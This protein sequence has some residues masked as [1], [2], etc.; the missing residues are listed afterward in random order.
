MRNLI[1]ISAVLSPFFLLGQ[2]GFSSKDTLQ[3]ASDS[4]YSRDIIRV[5]KELVFATSKNGVIALNE[6]KEETRQLI[7]GSP[8]GE[9]RSVISDGKTVYGMVSGDHGEVWRT[10]GKDHLL[11][12]KQAGMFFDDM[13]RTDHSFVVLG[14]PVNNEFVLYR[15][16]LTINKVASIE[17]PQSIGDEACYAAS[18]TTVLTSGTTIIFIS[19]GSSAVRY[20]RSDDNG[21]TWTST[22]L[23][24]QVGEGC[25]PF[26]I[27]FINEKDGMIV[28]GCYAKP[29][30]PATALYT[31]DGG[32]TWHTTTTAG[33][34][35]CVTGNEN[36]QFTCGTTGIEIST[37]K[38]KTWQPFDKGN[39]CALLLEKRYL[40]ATTNKGYCI[41]YKLR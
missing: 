21:K 29:N 10:K 26:S 39:F 9:F 33:Y 34:R 18:G 30:E 40:Y 22:E 37:D 16:D 3:F 4:S 20:H 6:K 31:N 11:V 36:V 5:G 2:T 12:S 1:V 35:S 13:A 17:G 32:L 25:G 41:R 19:G 28:G 38:G 8:S 24:M 23:P 14:D 7:P 15:I 27:H